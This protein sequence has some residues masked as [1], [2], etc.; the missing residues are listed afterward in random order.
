M[1]DV[2]Y[3]VLITNPAFAYLPNEGYLPYDR[4]MELDV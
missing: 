4:G 1:T 2:A 3:T